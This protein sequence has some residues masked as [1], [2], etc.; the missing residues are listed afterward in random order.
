V[1]DRTKIRVYGKGAFGN[2]ESGTYHKAIDIIN[3]VPNA[4]L[5]LIKPSLAI[6]CCWLPYWELLRFFHRPTFLRQSCSFR[7]SCWPNRATSLPC[8]G[9]SLLHA[10]YMLSLSVCGISLCTMRAI[11]LDRSLALHYHMR[12]PNVMTDQRALCTTVILWFI[13]LSLPFLRYIGGFKLYFVVV[14]VCIALCIL[15]STFSYIKIYQTVRRHQL[16]IHAQ[17]QAVQS[18]NDEH[19]Q[20]MV[21]SKE[22]AISTF[23]LHLYG[24]VLFSSIS[25]LANWICSSQDIAAVGVDFGIYCGIPKLLH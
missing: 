24:L 21:R 15:V 3:C 5:M 12:Y 22:S 4:P 14:V 9:T 23:I 13:C 18:L 6:L 1:F 20:D 7:P 2:K 16:E 17:Q 25:Y 10:K 11:S 19:N 8:T